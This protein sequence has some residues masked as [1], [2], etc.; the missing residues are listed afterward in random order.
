VPAEATRLHHRLSGRDRGLIGF[1]LA[2]TLVASVAMLATVNSDGSTHERAGCV[3]AD[4]AG[5][6]GSNRVN[7]CGK[8]ALQFC[9]VYAAQYATVA[10][11]CAEVPGWKPG[12]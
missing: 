10:R 12:S 4:V 5:V 2:G 1:A 6:M 9:H 8:Q 3:V 11:Q 7:G